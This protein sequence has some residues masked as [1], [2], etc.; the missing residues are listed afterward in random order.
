MLARF[1]LIGSLT[2]SLCSSCSGE[3]LPCGKCRDNQTEIEIVTRGA[4]VTS[5]VYTGPACE[6]A[7]LSSNT[8]ADAGYRSPGF[9]PGASSYRISGLAF[10][11][12]AVTLEFDGAPPLSGNFQVSQGTG[13]CAGM[14]IDSTP[15][16][17]PAAD[18]G[19]TN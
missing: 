19:A 13:C 17:L 12:C 5:L 14:F 4:Y 6:G 7:T 1:A 15:W 16:V 3:P 2:I 18:G 8:D 10:G 9:V 11:S